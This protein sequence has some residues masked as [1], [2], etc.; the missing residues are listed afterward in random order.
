[1]AANLV[2]RRQISSA[3]RLVTNHGG[4]G[5]VEAAVQHRPRNGSIGANTTVRPSNSAL[6]TA[7]LPALDVVVRWR[8]RSRRP[9]A[10]GR[11]RLPQALTPIVPHPSPA[12]VVR[13][14][15]SSARWKVRDDLRPER[16]A[17]RAVRE[18]DR[19]AE[20]PAPGAARQR[21]LREHAAEE[22]SVK[23]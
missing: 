22:S 17:Q 16:A 18:P 21:R 11:R 10:G 12:I 20:E 6:C 14:L 1:L 2:T 23:Q 4:F 5:E 19:F 13:R 8:E 9:A 15:A 3:R 7:P